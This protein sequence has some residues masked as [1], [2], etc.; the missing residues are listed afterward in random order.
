MEIPAN[1]NERMSDLPPPESLLLA[2][3]HNNEEAALQLLQ[4]ANVQEQLSASDSSGLTPLLAAAKNGSACLLK[5]LLHHGANPG[6]SLHSSG[7][8][9]LHLAAANGSLPAIQAIIQAYVTEG[10]PIDRRNANMDT[11]LMFAAA[12][13]RIGVLATLLKVR[14]LQPLL[15]TTV[16][17]SSGA[18][19]SPCAQVQCI[20]KLQHLTSSASHVRCAHKQDITSC[21]LLAHPHLAAPYGPGLTPAA[22]PPAG[23][24]RH[25]SQERRRRD[26]RAGGG[27]PPPRA[28]AAAAGGP[29]ASA[30]AVARCQRQR[31]PAPGVQVR[32]AQ[33]TPAPACRA[34]QCTAQ[35]PHGHHAPA[36]HSLC[37]GVH[38][39]GQQGRGR[40]C[41]GGSCAP[42]MYR[43]RRLPTPWRFTWDVL[44]AGPCLRAAL[45]VHGGR[46]ML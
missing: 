13:G 26:A 21:R 16:Q 6:A 4:A 8:T 10:I 30:A 34:H 44:R 22:N 27:V 28:A 20:I 5:A 40:G 23:R 19:C 43:T 45:Q 15:P 25:R 35:L 3:H 7:N 33:R 14:G 12:A 17:H 39:H 41:D 29:C 31:R 1:H 42:S 38:W 11:A 2:C 9:A 18:Y 37:R 32:C 24:G 36:G 46:Q